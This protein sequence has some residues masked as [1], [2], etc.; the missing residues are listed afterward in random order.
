[1][2]IALLSRRLLLLGLLLLASPGVR[3]LEAQEKAD[4][5][6][7][8]RDMVL[9]ALGTSPETGFMFGGVYMRQFKPGGAGP[10]TRSSS[11][12]F[13]A[14]YTLKNQILIS[15]YPEVITPRERWVIS[16]KN[17]VNYFPEDFWGIGPFT[18]ESDKRSVIYTQIHIEETLLHQV[19]PDLYAG[20]KG[21][22]SRISGVRFEDSE[23]NR[24]Y[25]SGLPGADGSTSAGAGWVVRYD[26]R[27]SLMTPTRGLLAEFINIFYP[28]WMGSTE[29]FTLYSLDLRRYRDLFGN[30]NSILALQLQARFTTGHPPFRDLPM[31]GGDYVMRGYY[32]GRYRD[33]NALQAEAEWRQQLAGRFG[34][35]VFA[36]SGE[37]W[38]R[39][40]NFDMSNYKWSAGLGLRYNINPEDPTNIRMDVGF[41]KESTGLYITFGEAF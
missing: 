12:L 10:K 40:A 13:S 30:A 1:M 32:A 28:G 7:H 31:L 16:G 23:G 21:R 22:Y 19:S 5:T 35:T 8:T 11:L 6:Y 38:R 37:V 17:Y 20:I 3:V 4:S 29:P 27:N 25:P 34:F 15:F 41:T 33:H 24:L 14:I 26:R 2:R 18:R 39:F 36:G 9:P